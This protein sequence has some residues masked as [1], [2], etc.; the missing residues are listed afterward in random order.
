MK[1]FFIKWFFLEL[2]GNVAKNEKNIYSKTNDSTGEHSLKASIR[3][4]LGELG[5]F[6]ESFKDNK[7]F[8]DYCLCY[9]GTVDTF[10]VFDVYLFFK[11]FMTETVDKSPRHKSNS[12][13]TVSSKISKW[14]V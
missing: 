4:Y 11:L 2:W 5:N 14:K 12:I 1:L 10:V 9:S 13:L 3:F 8:L 7:E 6:T